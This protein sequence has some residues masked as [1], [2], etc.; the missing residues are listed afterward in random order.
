MTNISS[1]WFFPYLWQESDPFTN[2]VK[3]T[4]SFRLWNQESWK[5][6]QECGSNWSA[7]N[8]LVNERSCNGDRRR[9]KT[10]NVSMELPTLGRK[11]S[12]VRKHSFTSLNLYVVHYPAEMESSTRT[13]PVMDG[14][15]AIW[16]IPILVN[17]SFVYWKDFSARRDSFFMSFFRGYQTSC[18]VTNFRLF[19]TFWMEW[20]W[21]HQ[22][23]KT[24]TVH[25]SKIFIQPR[26]IG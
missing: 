8:K 13:C 6:Q 21:M 17:Q 3:K 18:G 1:V 19:L 24:Q 11:R 16:F 14:L 9:K 2:P 4:S 23:F 7:Y 20:K 26:V 22:Y 15:I 25:W 12:P 10:H 5:R